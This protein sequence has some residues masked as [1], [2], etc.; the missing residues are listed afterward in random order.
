MAQDFGVNSTIVWYRVIT[1][2]QQNDRKNMSR[3]STDA[4]S[5]AFQ[6]DE[7]TSSHDEDEDPS[8]TAD[9][10]PPFPP[11][12]YAPQRVKLST[13]LYCS[14]DHTQLNV[15]LEQGG[16]TPIQHI[17][18]I[19]ASTSRWLWQ[20]T[21]P[22]HPLRTTL[23]GPLHAQT[24]Q[25]GS[26]FVYG[27]IRPHH[28]APMSSSSSATT[29]SSSP[30][31]GPILVVLRW[32]VHFWD[33]YYRDLTRSHVFITQSCIPLDRL[34]MATRS[35]TCSTTG[36]NNNSDTTTEWGPVHIV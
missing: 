23:F 8:R 6:P 15:I 13:F 30:P 7:E 4:S 16:L 33:V 1:Q 31:A 29:A 2:E 12:Q 26:A 27:S 18:A 5:I 9:D 14:V 25:L 10:R 35:S 32:L 36:G 17:H 24:T 22:N 20:H 34:Q 21:A 11:A 19:T 28:P 3:P